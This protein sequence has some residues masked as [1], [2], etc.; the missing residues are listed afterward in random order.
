MQWKKNRITVTSWQAGDFKITECPED[1]PR[2]FRLE[3]LAEPDSEPEHFVSLKD[4]QANAALR[5]ELELHREEN[6]RLRQELDM[7]RQADAFEKNASQHPPIPAIAPGTSG[8]ANE[9][10]DRA[11]DQVIAETR[12]GNELD[13]AEALE[14]DPWFDPPLDDGR[15][16]PHSNGVLNGAINGH[17]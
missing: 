6:A 15:G 13:D 1:A 8:W 2:P 4:A 10:M 5:N 3:S 9:D 12:A 17:A 7:K 11:I 16:I 14:H